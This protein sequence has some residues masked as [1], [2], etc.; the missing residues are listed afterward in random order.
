MIGLVCFFL[1]VLASPFTS[2]SRHKAENAVVC[3]ENLSRIA[4]RREIERQ[5]IQIDTALDLLESLDARTDKSGVDDLARLALDLRQQGART[6]RAMPF[7]M[8]RL[9]RTFG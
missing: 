5:I 7:V 9:W 1:S 8:S 3:T 4:E 6:L 2:A